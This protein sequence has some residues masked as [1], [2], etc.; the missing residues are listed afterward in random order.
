MKNLP[1]V[2]K[3]LIVFF[4]AYILITLLPLIAP[5]RTAAVST[6]NTFQQVT[7]NAFHPTTRT[8]F[9]LFDGDSDEFDYSVYI[10]S[11]NQWKSSPN[12]KSIQPSFILNQN[13]RLTAFGPF[14]MLISLIIASPINW[15]RKLIS[16]FIGGILICILLAM[17]Y[18]AMI[19]ENAPVLRPEGFSAW[20]KISGLFNNAFRTQEFLALII[21]PVWAISSL[22]K[23]EWK[24]FMT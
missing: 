3:F 23:Q 6:Y 13:A 17:K 22:R 15:K 1:N 24:W 14:I 16:L 9:R 2:L 10:Y 18:T 11:L 4:I 7:F 21:I 19:D 8:D 20:I 5:V 12:K